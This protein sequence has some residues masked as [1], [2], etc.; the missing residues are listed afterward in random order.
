MLVKLSIPAVVVGTGYIPLGQGKY[1]Q[2]DPEDFERLSKYHWFAK[3]SGSA[4]YAVRKVTSK[5]SV[6]FVRM[7][8]QIMH[9]PRGLVVHHYNGNSL[10]NHKANLLNCSKAEHAFYH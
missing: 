2:V 6:F 7:H 3:Q 4:W 10:D 1:A 5:R 8:R 9:T